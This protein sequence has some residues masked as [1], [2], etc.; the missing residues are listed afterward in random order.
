MKWLSLADRAHGLLSKGYNVV[1]DR[2][3]PEVRDQV[4]GALQTY[5]RRRQQLANVDS[6][7]KK[8]GNAL[9]ETY[10]EYFLK[11]INRQMST[12]RIYVDSRDRQDPTNSS[13][14]DFEIS[15]SLSLSISEKN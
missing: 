7:L 13:N 14:T 6:N 11:V 3:E 9:R 2:L 5:S 12:Y 8:V 4:G 10:S 1:S 15:L